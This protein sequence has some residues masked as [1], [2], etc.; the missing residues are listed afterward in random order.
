MSYFVCKDDVIDAIQYFKELKID[1]DDSLFL[2]LM[3]K[4]AGVS[5]TFPVSF[6]PG[7]LS[8]EQKKDILKTIWMF[9]G[10]F[11]QNENVERK[12]L[13]FPN[14]FARVR[15]YQPGT[16]FSNIVGR[17]KDTVEKK[18]IN[19]PLYTDN[20]S[21][22]KLKKNYQEVIMEKYLKGNKISFK[23]MIAWVFRF[24]SFEFQ[25]KPTAKEF[26]RV[27]DR[28]AKKFLRVNKRDFLWLFEDDLYFNRLE[29][30]DEGITGIEIRDQFDFSSS[31]T[32]E[33]TEDATNLQEKQNDIVSQD[34][35][36]EYLTLNGDN[37]SDTDILST[38]LE[39]KQ[40]VLTGVPGVGKTRYTTMLQEHEEFNGIVEMV[41]F[42]PNFSYEDFIYSETLTVEDG[43]TISKRIPGVFLEF[44]IRAAEDSNPEHK[45]LFIIDEI[46]RGDI[47]EIFGEVILTL[48]RG[49]K[50]KL[51]RP[52]DKMRVDN[53]YVEEITE[54]TIPDNVYI[55]A[56]MNTSDR[57]IAFLDLAIRRRFAFIDLTP[58]YD[59]LSEEI[60][61]EEDGVPVDA[62]DFGNVLRMIN[63][64]ILSTL[65]EPE[66]LLGQS[67]FIPA[68]N[69]KVWTGTTLKNQF[70]FV[71]LPTLKEYSF[72][73]QN[74]LNT[75]IGENLA[76]SLQDKEEFLQAF[77]AEFS[78]E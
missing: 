24:T 26:T 25:E 3:A 68:D 19:V 8:P 17:I 28:Y 46:N 1:D 27:I 78:M 69:V 30:S 18:N 75:I 40:I 45:H 74:V 21:M 9:A 14:S 62:I 41:Q 71:L 23:H 2:F 15:F 36:I 61:F 49:Y 44:L 5:T 67:Y 57:N 35:I 77:I 66:L 10:L 32:P 7:K 22:L 34:T 65:H 33:I 70:N 47:A 37:P 54:L 64:R 55:V 52:I 20:D 76:N 11:D 16:T 56:T 72:N 50:A 38:L 4:R 13:M 58:N 39:K 29:V 51:A 63:S 53:V 59:Y 43:A 48:D 42:H 6:A 73:S 31:G 12:G 60:S